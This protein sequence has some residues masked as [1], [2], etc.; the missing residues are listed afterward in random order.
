MRLMKYVQSAANKELNLFPRHHNNRQLMESQTELELLKQAEDGNQQAL[1]ML[2]QLNHQRLERIV[3][4]RM[5]SR[6]RGRLDEGDIVQESFLEA[7]KRFQYYVENRKTSFFLWLRYLTLQKLNELHRHHFGTQ[8]RDRR[9][10]VSIFNR[11]DSPATTAQIAGVLFDDKTSPSQALIRDEA[12]VLI[13]NALGE[14]DPVDQEVLALRHF[15]QLSNVEVA[16]AL[17]LETSAASK[18]FVRALERLKSIIECYE[19]PTNPE[20]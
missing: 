19:N 16:D 7:T 18:R 17:G 9:R 4:F 5:D 12:R 6:L 10:E 14:M 8:S 20:G 15:E 2:L 13:E 11:L 1:G 3:R